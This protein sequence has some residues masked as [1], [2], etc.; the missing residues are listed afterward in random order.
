MSES[1]Q[2]AANGLDLDLSGRQVGDYRLLRR[3]GRGAMAEVYLAEQLSLRR[4]VAF[5]I[6]KR[7]L[8]KD[9]TYVRRF[10]MEAQAAASL[11]HA[12]IVQIH[13]VGCVDGIH[14]IA[15]EYVEGQNLRELLLRRGLPDVKLVVSVM[16]QVAAALAKAADQGIVHR[17][18]KP[19]NIMLTK[20]GEVKV[21]DFGLARITSEGDSLNLTQTGIT[22]GTPL[23]MSPEQVEG[24]QLDPRSDIYSFGVTCYQMLAGQPPFRGET[25]LSVAVQHVK[26][27]PERLENR[28]PDLPPGLC[29]TVHKML[30]KDPKDRYPDARELLRELRGLEIEGLA[31][32]WPVEFDE[33]NTTEAAAFGDTT[34]DATR[35]LGGVMK[36]QALA[37]HDG[38]RWR[39]GL[40]LAA[41][42]AFVLGGASAL[43]LRK[44]FLL[45]A[46]AAA[47][48]G[49]L[50]GKRT[51]AAEQ[52]LFAV[53]NGTEAAW[54]SVE[55]Y[56]PNN[57]NYVP[58]ANQQLARYYLDHERWDDA[59]KLF[60]QFAKYDDTEKS[61]RAFG[62]AGEC[63]VYYL[64][65]NQKK[66]SEKALELSK[67]AGGLE[68][69]KLDGLLDRQMMQAVGYALRKDLAN[70]PQ[71]PALW[72]KWIE[73]HFHDESSAPSAAIQPTG[74]GG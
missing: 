64:E 28:R 50:I 6:L 20:A 68:P 46:S 53:E 62:L 69:S 13:E 30:A 58:R 52:Y 18:I 36:T 12:H 61:Y 41:I 5:K 47:S 65:K 3:L 51:T 34:F 4:Q 39:R 73:N 44:P 9:A 57:P 14:Y 74:G 27:V 19:E 48:D 37:I 23:Y 55:L 25:A 32:D 70:V 24:R 29:R 42:V 31:V 10:H 7:E 43:L 2:S 72:D 49:G 54:K 33:R 63:V 15:Q 45:A 56:F 26:A 66:S 71:S 16:R 38:R 35:R 22:M 60:D 8:A 40:T 17:D 67:V 59:L 21:A 1:T 11:V